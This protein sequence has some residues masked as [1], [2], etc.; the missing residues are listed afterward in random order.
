MMTDH[1]VPSI[2]VG[3]DAVATLDRLAPYIDRRST[4]FCTSYAWL[5]AATRHLPGTP[6]AVTVHSLDQPVALAALTVT[7]RRG[8]RR[9]ELLGGDLNDYGPLFHDDHEAAVTLAEAIAGWVL[10]QRRWQLALGQLDAGD[11]VLPALAKRLPGAVVEAGPP[12]PQ[13]VRV[14]TEYLISRNRR[15]NVNNATNR[16]TADGRTWERVV[17]GDAENLERWLPAM[18][19]LRRGRDHASGRRSHLDEP[20]VLAFYEA[21]VRDAVPR[22]RAAINLLVVDGEV[23]G[24]ALA[25]YDGAA[26]RLFD[27]RVAEDFQRYRGGM[28]CDLMAV[29]RAVEDPDVT[30]FD[31]LRG[32]TPSKFAN[33]EVRRVGLQAASCALVTVV[34]DWEDA[35]RRRIKA[36]LPE[37]AV[38]KL[39]AR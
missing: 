19:R 13:I 12:M 4:A 14:G 31:W 32:S 24:Y 2:T 38:R 3:D 39:V 17:V 11:L 16:I 7:H 18:V 10:E 25:M 36:A 8:V 9:I 29:R 6:V 1:L 33:Y 20:A 23:A 5:A 22:G 34:Q 37:A 30:T 28:V 21:V 26:H 27:G 15:K 35:A